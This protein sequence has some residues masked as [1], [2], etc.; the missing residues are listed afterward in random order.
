MT[1][2]NGDVMASPTE[3][4]KIAHALRILIESL[5]SEDEED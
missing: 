4:A 1:I 5:F 3:K 2:E